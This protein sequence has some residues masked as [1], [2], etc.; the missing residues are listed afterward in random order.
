MGNMKNTF[1]S[2]LV[3][4]VVVAGS[5]SSWAETAT[6]P[7]PPSNSRKPAG[8]AG[9]DDRQ[10]GKIKRAST[11][12]AKLLEWFGS[13]QSRDLTPDGRMTLNWSWSNSS[14]GAGGA[15]NVR[16]SREGQVE[17]YSARRHSGVESRKIEFTVQTD[18]DLRQY[19]DQWRR[20]GWNVLSISKPMPQPDGTIKRTAD[21]SAAGAT[22]EAARSYDD[23]VISGIRRGKT[24]EV[25]MLESFGP[26]YSRDLA[27]D[28][29]LQ[30]TWV[31]KNEAAATAPAGELKANLSPEGRVESYSARS[32]K[33]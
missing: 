9:Y 17:A 4:G 5:L 13:P 26:A 14:V 12:E 10:I 1:I 31:L 27:P 22:P 7:Q 24:T 33:S 3:A 18:D 6:P 8:A 21:L 2:W 15:L 28:G 16:L 29:R 19:L 20:E 32:G 25:E 23:R 11:T 30:M